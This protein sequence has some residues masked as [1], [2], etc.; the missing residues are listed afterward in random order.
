MAHIMTDKGQMKH[1]VLCK[2]IELVKIIIIL[3]EYYVKKLEKIK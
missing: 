3:Q 2:N 1:A